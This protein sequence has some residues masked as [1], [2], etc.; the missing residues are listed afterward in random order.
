MRCDVAA[1]VIAQGES[2]RP[3]VGGVTIERAAALEEAASARVTARLT[4]EV[5]SP[6]VGRCKSCDQSL[7]TL[8]RSARNSDTICATV[9]P[10]SARPAP[11]SCARAGMSGPRRGRLG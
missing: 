6:S 2:H 8:A 9:K 5:R 11:C 10:L 3:G 7:I 4:A 1:H